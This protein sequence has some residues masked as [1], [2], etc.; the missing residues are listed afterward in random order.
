[1]ET[2]EFLVGHELALSSQIGRHHFFNL[3]V[4][5]VTLSY[6]FYAL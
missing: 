1:M 4:I 3:V 2:V 6:V 5:E